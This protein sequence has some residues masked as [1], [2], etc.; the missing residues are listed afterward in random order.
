MK[1]LMTAVALSAALFSATP[2]QATPAEAGSSFDPAVFATRAN[3]LQMHQGL[4]LATLGTMAATAGLGL[5]SSRGGAPAE[6]RDMHLALAGL[7]TGLYVSTASLAWWAPP[8]TVLEDDAP[9]SSINIHRTLGWLHA[10]GLLGTIGLG[11]A[12]VMNGGS[13][14]PAHGLLGTT[15]LG[16]MAASAGIVAFG[17]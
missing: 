7:T 9:L 11:T 5:W 1:H 8:Q 3:Q 15:T 4:A 17:Q 14:T 6:W 13:F 10:A 2:A 16:L 12:V